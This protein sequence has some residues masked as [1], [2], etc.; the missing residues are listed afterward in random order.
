MIG[1][2]MNERSVE[3]MTPAALKVFRFLK[4]CP[5]RRVT[6]YRTLHS[7]A[8]HFQLFFSVKK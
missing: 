8:T 4:R 7:C 3:N 6:K 1:C 5:R 2:E